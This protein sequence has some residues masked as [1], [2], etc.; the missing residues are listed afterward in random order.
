MVQLRVV[1]HLELGGPDVAVTVSALEVTVVSV[2]ARGKW[3]QPTRALARGPSTAMV[4]C[5]GRIKA[6]WK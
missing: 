4:G 3:R 6:P 1:R 2:V 5:L